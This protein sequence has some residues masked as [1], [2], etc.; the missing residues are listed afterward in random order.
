MSKP[1]PVLSEQGMSRASQI[2]PHLPFGETTLWAWSKCGKFPRPIKLSANM[3]CWKNAEVL[4]WLEGRWTPEQE[5]S[6]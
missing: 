3:T 2:L 5:A 4:A 1:I 6:A